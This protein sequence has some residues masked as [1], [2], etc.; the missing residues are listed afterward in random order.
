M[1]RTPSRQTLAELALDPFLLTLSMRDPGQMLTEAQVA[2]FLQVSPDVLSQWRREG[3]QPPIWSVSPHTPGEPNR[4]GRTAVRYQLGALRDYSRALVEAAEAAFA[5]A[6]VAEPASP[7]RKVPRHA[8]FALFLATAP[9]DDEWLF[10]R[11]GPRRRPVDFIYS[12]DLE[13]GN[14]DAPEWMTLAAYLEALRTASH[15]EAL[16]EIAAKDRDAIVAA[17][18]HAPSTQGRARS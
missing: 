1:P 9:A 10:M 18:A 3:K 7:K 14:D 17:A 4:S 2:G 16:A 15:E 12:L 8:S 13:P 6:D 11:M 5:A